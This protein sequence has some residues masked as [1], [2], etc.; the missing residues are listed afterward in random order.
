MLQ[1][2]QRRNYTPDRIAGYFRRSPKVIGANEVRAFQL[3]MGQEKL[4][5]VT[6]ALRMGVLRFC[7]ERRYVGA[8]FVEGAAAPEPS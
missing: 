1:E 8:T 6:F 7:T 2:L 5:L 3:Y 4:A